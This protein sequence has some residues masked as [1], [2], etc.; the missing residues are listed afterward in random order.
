MMIEI[1]KQEPPQFQF[2][3]QHIW[4]REGKNHPGN[5]YRILSV[6]EGLLTFDEDL[7]IFCYH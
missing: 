1:R 2:P 3:C 6:Q 4:A 7:I 5:N